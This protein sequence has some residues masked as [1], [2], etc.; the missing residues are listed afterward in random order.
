MSWR[1]PRVTVPRAMRGTPSLIRTTKMGLGTAGRVK[2][3][4]DQQGDGQQEHGGHEGRLGTV[5]SM[6]NRAHSECPTP[7]IIAV[8]GGSV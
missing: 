1:N 6:E 7:R 8:A 4:S 2:A 5:Q 3:P